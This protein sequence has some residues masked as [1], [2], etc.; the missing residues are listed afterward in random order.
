M[1]HGWGWNFAGGSGDVYA[2]R[3]ASDTARMWSVPEK[4][5]V[6]VKSVF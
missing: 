3:F 1:R 2:K 6:A 4:S 5:F